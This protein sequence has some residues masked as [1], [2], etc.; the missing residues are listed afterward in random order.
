MQTEKKCMAVVIL[1]PIH[2]KKKKIRGL[3]LNGVKRLRKKTKPDFFEPL[4]SQ[5]AAHNEQCLQN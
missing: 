1:G 2:C 4:G 3:G 5:N